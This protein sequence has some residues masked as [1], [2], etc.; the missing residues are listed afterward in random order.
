MTE[1]L[2]ETPIMAYH[3]QEKP[4]RLVNLHE[5]KMLFDNFANTPTEELSLLRKTARMMLADNGK[6][7][8]QEQVHFAKKIDKESSL[9][10][11]FRIHGEKYRDD[12]NEWVE[13]KKSKQQGWEQ[14]MFTKYG[15][16]WEKQV[17]ESDR[18]QLTYSVEDL[19]VF[20]KHL[21]IEGK[22]MRLKNSAIE[23]LLNKESKANHEKK[24]E[25]SYPQEVKMRTL[26]KYPFL[27]EKEVHKVVFSIKFFFFYIR[28]MFNTINLRKMKAIIGKYD[29]AEVEREHNFAEAV[30]EVKKIIERKQALK[31]LRTD[32]SS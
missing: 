19:E 28:Q 11:F 18:K 27:D 6:F 15:E 30:E 22:A 23:K 4:R 3:K 7:V 2:L 16:N 8:D 25:I 12:Y 9:E 31:A 21:M 13:I 20:A 29:S 17:T 26:A 32:R 24:K 14:Q 5:K 10:L 1:G